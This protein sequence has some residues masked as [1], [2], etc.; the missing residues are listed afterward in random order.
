MTP[1]K[2]KTMSG[3]DLHRF[4]FIPDRY[5]GF[6]PVEWN[7]LADEY[8]TDPSAKVLH[9]TAGIPAWPHYANAPHADDWAKAAMKVTH[10]TS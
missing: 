4:A 1:E 10:A 8:G 3:A 5:I 2:V 7:W 6:L 9:W